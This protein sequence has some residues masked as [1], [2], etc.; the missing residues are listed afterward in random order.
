MT[1]EP[2]CDFI[3]IVSGLPRSGTSMM[4]RMLEAG[5]MPVVVDHDRKPDADNPNGYYEI[6]AVKKLKEDASWVES[7]VGKALKAIYLLLYDLPKDFRYRVIFVR[8]SLQE[9]I[10]SQDTMLRRSGASTG[11]MDSQRLARHF[12][13]QLH[14]LAEWLRQQP[15]MAVLFVDYADAVTNP[16][17]TAAR[18]AR[19]LGGC[20]EPAKMAAVVDPN[21]Y[22]QRTQAVDTVEKVADEPSEPSHLTF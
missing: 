5:G 15:N 3:T 10:A 22:R 6:E 2:R 17:G 19:F 21:L 11:S 14:H 18:V 12:E 1:S 7:A 13:T 16:S 4:M 8:R 20:V 9:V